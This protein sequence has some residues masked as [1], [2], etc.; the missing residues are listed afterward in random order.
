MLAWYRL[1]DP[2]VVANCAEFTPGD[3]YRLA[4][5]AQTAVDY[6]ELLAGMRQKRLTDARIRRM[7]WYGML[8]VTEADLKA[9]PA[10]TVLLGANERGREALRFLKKHSDLPILTKRADY[11][12]CTDTVVRQFTLALRAQS[13]YDLIAPEGERGYLCNAPY[14][15]NTQST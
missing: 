8:G 14:L 13:L 2:Q 6:E 9:T 4:E 3:S 1:S 7:L 12:Q 11:K 10:Y 5:L 15:K